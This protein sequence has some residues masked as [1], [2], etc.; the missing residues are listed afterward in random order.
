MMNRILTP[1]GPMVVAATTTSICLLEF[2]DRRMLETQLKRLVRWMP[3]TFVPGSNAVT[4]AGQLINLD[5]QGNRIAALTFGPRW[6]IILVGRNKIVPDLEE[7]MWDRTS[8]PQ[9]DCQSYPDS[10]AARLL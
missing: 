1:L 8:T 4:E 6:V 10:R 9:C 7:A 3:C 2:A 5:A